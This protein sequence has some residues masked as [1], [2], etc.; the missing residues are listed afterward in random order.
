MDWTLINYCRNIMDL[1]HSPLNEQGNEVINTNHKIKAA[2]LLKDCYVSRSE[3][4]KGGPS[5]LALS[6]LNN[7]LEQLENCRSVSTFS[8]VYGNLSQL[9]AVVKKSNLPLANTKSN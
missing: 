8:F 1:K 7:K 2:Q 6:S 4:L 5:V 3:I 9:W